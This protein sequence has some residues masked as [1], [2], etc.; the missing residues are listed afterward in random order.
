M[1]TDQMRKIVVLSLLIAVAVPVL[2]QHDGRQQRSGKRAEITELVGDLNA[3]QKS[4]IET[5]TRQ[6]KVRVE[7]LRKQQHNVRDSIS[8]FMELDGD[9]SKYLYPLFDR[10]A[11]LQVAI[12]R[13]MYTSKRQID[14]VLTPQQ[15]TALRESLRRQHRRK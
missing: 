3:K 8:H 1:N 12:N 4:K 2:A 5:I 9:Q 7:A 11:K 14:E 10:E 13:E 15:R 6:S